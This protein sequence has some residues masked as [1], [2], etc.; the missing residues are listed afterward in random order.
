[1]IPRRYGFV[2]PLAALL[3]CAGGAT[4]RVAPDNATDDTPVAL[5]PTP[6][7]GPADTVTQ[8]AAL[9]PDSVSAA[10]RA[11]KG[12]AAYGTGEV[13]ELKRI[14]QWTRTGIGESR[15]LVIRDANAWAEFWSELGVGDRPD[16]DF[17]QNVVVAVAT[18]QRPSGGYEIAV[19]RIHQANG[20]LTVDVVETAPGP[21][22]M[23]TAALT[24]PVDVVVVPSFAAKS[25]SFVDRKE[26]RGC[27]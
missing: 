7:A 5:S 22:C 21:N 12:Y 26:V 24:Q 16:V 19:D 13:L 8:G 3:G 4:M 14:G 6:E 10:A 2:F 15:R 25:W 23:S 11:G 27:R 9:A 1:M 18:G 20:E 17:T